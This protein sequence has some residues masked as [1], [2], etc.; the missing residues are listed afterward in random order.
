MSSIQIN[1]GFWFQSFQF[2]NSKFYKVSTQNV[3]LKTYLQWINIIL[4]KVK[5]YNSFKPIQ[6]RSSRPEVFCKKGVPRNFAEF[7][8]NTCASLF[9]NNAAG[10]NF[11]KKE[12]LAQVCSCSKFSKISKKSFSYR[13]HPVAD[14]V[15]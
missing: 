12:N 4:R 6:L 14:F 2:K 9:L 5:I 13:T 3:I 1:T 7:T 11:I 15:N 8:G 10:C